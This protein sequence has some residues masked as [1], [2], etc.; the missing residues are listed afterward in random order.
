MIAMRSIILLLP[1]LGLAG[2]GQNSE[3][4]QPSQEQAP[5]SVAATQSPVTITEW[6]VPWEKTRPRDP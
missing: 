6:T 1:T 2:C 5:P 4:A 3:A